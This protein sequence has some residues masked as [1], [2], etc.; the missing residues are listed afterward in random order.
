MPTQSTDVNG[1]PFGI[2]YAGSGLT[3][4]I[5]KGVEVTGTLAAVHSIHSDNTLIN[6]GSL[7]GT[8][9]GVYF[10]GTGGASSSVVKNLA[11]GEI[12]GQYGIALTNFQGNAVIENAGEIDAAQFGIYV[13]AFLGSAKVTNEGDIGGQIAVQFY[14]SS[15]ATV[16]NHGHIDGAQYGVVFYGSAVGSSGA[17][18]DNFGH[19]DGGLYA[20][21]IEGISGQ[22]SKVVNHA[23]AVIDGSMV[24]IYSSEALNLKNEGKIKGAVVSSEYADKLVNKGKLSGDVALG[25]GD[26]VF[27]NKGDKAKSGMIDSGEGN[28][29]LVL[30]A[31]AEKLVFDSALNAATNVDTIKHFASGKDAIYL[32]EDIFS[33]ITPGTLSSSAFHK[34]TSAA[35]AD[36]RIIYD[37]KSGALYYDPDGVGGVGQTQFAKLDGGPKLKAGDFT[38]GEYSFAI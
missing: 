23:G 2:D 15:A 24:A 11:S 8:T 31:K 17:K 37:K 25:E 34:G 29:L 7:F 33:M 5:K 30:A 16:E 20:I 27:K 35:D 28:D 12:G 14:G 3:W 36:D 26:D 18:V 22:S 1:T 6:K 10:E 32:D 38:V 9:V 4:T 21:V 19:I 13:Y